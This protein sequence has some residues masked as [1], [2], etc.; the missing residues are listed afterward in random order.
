MCT[1]VWFPDFCARTRDQ[2]EAVI[3][4]QA[5]MT[6]GTP[7]FAKDHCLCPV[8]LMSTLIEAGYSL[9]CWREGDPGVPGDLFASPCGEGDLA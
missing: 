3:G 1:N 6:E 4:M 7:R 8:D 2:L 9:R 5:R